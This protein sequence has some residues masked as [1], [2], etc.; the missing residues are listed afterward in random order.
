MGP[1]CLAGSA[2][3]HTQQDEHTFELARA[4]A[5]PAQ[6]QPR[7]GN[8]K[9][10]A[11]WWLRQTSCPNVRDWILH[12]FPLIW[13]LAQ[14]GSQPP[15]PPLHSPNHAGANEHAEHLDQD[16]TSLLDSG[17]I[18]E[19][20]A[21]QLT[22][23]SPLNVVPKPGSTKLRTILDLRH[24]NDYVQCPKFQYEELRS[25]TS[26]AEPNDWMFSLDLASGFHQIDMHPSAW[27]FLGFAWRGKHYFF[28]VLPFGLKSAPWCFTKV[29]R[30]VVQELRQKGVP[31]LAYLD[32]FWF[33]L[34]SR[35]SPHS[36]EFSRKW[37]ISVFEAAGLTIQL[38]KSHLQLTRR[39]PSHLGFVVD[40]ALGVFEVSEQRWQRLQAAL[41]QALKN[42]TVQRTLLERI[43]G[44]L[45]SMRLALGPVCMLFT[46]VMYSAIAASLGHLSVTVCAALRAELSFWVSITRTAFTCPIWPCPTK[47]DV[48][49]SSDAGARAWGAVCG[50]KQAHG[51]FSLEERG[52]SS[53]LRELWAVRRALETFGPLLS[54]CVVSLR[55]DN[56]NVPLCLSKGS[57][58]PAQQAEAVHVFRLVHSFAMAKLETIWVPREQNREADALTHMHDSDDWQLDPAVF[59]NLDARWGPHSIDRFSSHTN[60]LIPTFNS[61]F[62]CPGTHG[63]DAFAQ[64]DWAAHNNW[65]NAPFSRIGQVLAIL[66]HQ[67]AVA[68]LIT[69]FWPSALWWPALMERAGQFFRP[70]VRDCVEL[71][72][73]P[74]L[75][76][77][78][79]S[80]ANQ[81]G[82]GRPNWR[83]LALRIGPAARTAVG[84]IAVPHNAHMHC[85]PPA[86]R[87]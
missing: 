39:L 67:G 1:R 64:K 70:I 76:R 33:A 63:V 36:L 41:K 54:N 34:S 13:A 45:V 24:V 71:T 5:Q 44:M 25:I 80:M 29:M 69:P 8:L 9:R 16:I 74:G 12:G 6:P 56:Q 52:A 38:S 61:R 58:I 32:D 19:C 59:R 85:A 77:P 22:V 73:S 82:V 46:R 20:S 3:A 28:K 43:A 51:Q 81:A 62:W 65:C 68:T 75:F 40:T 48:T 42:R 26:L 30:V 47:A 87:P 14:D 60:H 7:A 27:P 55:T 84:S 11:S 31:V 50:D 35:L 4:P 86:L 23:V 17:A 78:G 15:P 10:H 57:R 66:A 49:I 53:T 37:V 83:V 72:P 18:Q 2:L 21:G 79:L